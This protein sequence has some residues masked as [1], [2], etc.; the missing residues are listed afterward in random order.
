MPCNILY[1]VSLQQDTLLLLLYYLFSNVPLLFTQVP[2]DSNDSSPDNNPL[3]PVSIH[4][5]S[6]Q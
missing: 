5:S 3:F 2:H 1:L 6:N 4:H